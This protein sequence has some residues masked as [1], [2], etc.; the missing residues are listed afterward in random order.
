MR[1]VL[2]AWQQVEWLQIVADPRPYRN[3][4]HLSIDAMLVYSFAR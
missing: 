4:L 2:V 1:G 3:G